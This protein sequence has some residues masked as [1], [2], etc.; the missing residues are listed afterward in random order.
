MQLLPY[1]TL[2]HK[3]APGTP[4]SVCSSL[5]LTNITLHTHKNIIHQFM[6]YFFLLSYS[7]FNGRTSYTEK[8]SHSSYKYHKHTHT[9][10]DLLLLLVMAMKE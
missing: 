7:F 8:E 6:C 9:F 1:F 2:R 3:Q 5:F 4:A 10:L